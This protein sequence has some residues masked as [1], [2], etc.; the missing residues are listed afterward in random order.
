M[1]GAHLY[2]IDVSHHPAE[3]DDP[4]VFLAVNDALGLVTE[5]LSLDVL[6]ERVAQ[7]APELFAL[8]VLPGLRAELAALPARFQ[9]RIPLPA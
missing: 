9:L 1:Q 3:G 7:I 5:A 8:N 4:A 6:Q 2:I